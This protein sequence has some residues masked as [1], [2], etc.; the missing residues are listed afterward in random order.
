M[1]EISRLNMLEPPRVCGASTIDYLMGLPLL[2]P[3]ITS[4]TISSRPIDLAA[5]HADLHFMVKDGCQKDAYARN[6]LDMPSTNLI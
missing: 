6:G 5:D 2:V 3:E 1:A 4:F